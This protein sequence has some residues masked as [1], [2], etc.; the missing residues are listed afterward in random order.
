MEQ[1][2]NGDLPSMAFETERLRKRRGT[3]ACRLRRARDHAAHGRHDWAV[4]AV[5]ITCVWVR[6][7]FGRSVCGR[8]VSSRRVLAR[9]AHGE[10]TDEEQRC[11]KCETKVAAVNHLSPFSDGRPFCIA[12]ASSTAIAKIE[13]FGKIVADDP[14]DGDGASSV[15]CVLRG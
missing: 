14:R 3:N 1:D 11:P 9:A 10:H 2:G 15:A 12:A 7:F 6:P 4:V 5:V 8:S 13:V